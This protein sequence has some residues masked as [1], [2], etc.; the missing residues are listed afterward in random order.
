[1][2]VDG[3]SIANRAFYGIPLLTNK[4]GLYTNAVYGFLNIMFSMM[5]KEKPDF[6]GVAF[7]VSAPTFRHKQVEDYKGTRKGMPKE[8]KEQ[9]PLLKEV[10]QAMEVYC[11]EKEGYEAD[12]VLGTLAKKAEKEG[13]EVVVV[14]GDRDLL[15]VT[16]EKIQLKIPKTKKTGTEIE[17][18]YSKDVMEKYG[19]SPVAFIDVKGLMGDPSDNI[20]GVPGVGE[21][22]AL[23]LIQEYGSMEKLYEHV[24]EMKTSKLKENLQTYKE[25]AFES[26]ML[27]TIVCD[28]PLDLKL[29]SFQNERK[30]NEKTYEIF[31]KLEFRKLL[32]RFQTDDLEEKEPIKIS[33][34]D[35]LQE[36]VTDAKTVGINYFYEA[37]IL[38]LAIESRQKVFYKEYDLQIKKDKKEMKLFFEDTSFLKIIHDSKMLRHILYQNKL[39]LEGEVFD[40]FIAAYLIHPQESSYDLGMLSETFLQNSRKKNLEEFLGKGKSA[41]KWLDLQEEERA[42]FLIDRVMQLFPLYQ[43]LANRLEK[44]NMKELFETIEMPLIKVLFEMEVEGICVDKEALKTYGKELDVLIEGV[45]TEIH[46]EAGETFNIN[47]PKQLG[48]I[49]FEKMDI[50]PIKKTK[51]GYST[52][53]DVLETLQEKYPIVKKVLEYRQYVKLKSTYVEGLLQVMT[54]ENKIHSSFNQT[55]TATGRISSTEPNLQNIPIKMELGRRIRKVFI[56]KSDDYIFLDAD[57]SQ[58]EL[59]V[60]AAIA[61]DPT[62]MDAFVNNIDIHALTA[63]QVLHIPIEEVSSLQR[64]NAKAVNFGIVYGISAFALSEDLKIS[65]KEAKAYIEGYF[66]K[67]PKVKMYL[68][69]VIENAIR[70]GFVTTLYHRKREIPELSSSNFNIKEFGKR[71]AMNTPIQGTAADIIKIAMIKVHNS[72]KQKKLNSK[73]IL[74]VHDELLLEV[75][76]PEL[77]E[78]KALLKYEME[79]AT[80]MEVPLTVDVHTGSNWFEVK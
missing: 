47:S 70:D 14:S 77:E 55:I 44:E 74:T 41:K 69:E 54:Q 36:I 60:L 17:A 72:L 1:M 78:V 45:E 51:T 28:V 32:D 48:V 12:D 2:L 66:E 75:Y 19:V 39:S 65:Q 68:D 79:N 59:R 49:L 61:K 21:K 4:E 76:K 37:P 64:S 26:K 58:I 42:D 18:Y 6:L 63:S 34:A 22:T 80:H 40:T 20:K 3:L 35:A 31:K 10:L 57:Y 46:K 25:Q 7:D 67:Y 73:L 8:L 9:I 24:P 56:P 15:Q 53:A 71:I 16:S 23:K 5:D 50:P 13:F 27:A 62:M 11:I 29:E 30:L 33:K 52:A 38:G 43:T